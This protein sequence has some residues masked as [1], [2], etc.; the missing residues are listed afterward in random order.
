MSDFLSLFPED[1]KRKGR[2]IKADGQR[3]ET[4]NTGAQ[5][6]GAGSLLTG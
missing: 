2:R 4:G 5:A 3:S 6:N 1:A